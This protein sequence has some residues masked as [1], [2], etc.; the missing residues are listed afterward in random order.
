MQSGQLKITREAVFLH[1]IFC[2]AVV[3]L[4]IN[5]IYFYYRFMLRLTGLTTFTCLFFLATVY[6]GR[7]LCKT[8]YL[9][10]KP[11]HFSLYTVLSLMLMII[12]WPLVAKLIFHTP[13]D[14]REFSATTLPFFIIG[15]VM[16]ILIKLTRA[17]IQKQILDAQIKAEQKQSELDLLQSQLSPHF[18]FNTLNNL[19]GISITQHERVPALLLQLSDLLRYSVYD[20]K[21]DFVTLKE[22]LQYINNYISFEKIRMSDR[23]VLHTDIDPVY[24]G[25]IKIA[26]MVLIIFVENAFKHASNTLDQKIFIDIALTISENFI[27]FSVK[28]SHSDGRNENNL[29]PKSAGLGIANTVKRLYLL[30]EA[31]YELKRYSEN[32]LYIV[33]LRLKI[34]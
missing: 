2:L 11:F 21:K 8:W 16:G 18:L 27:V 24:S 4:V 15:L 25:S 17:S 13:G 19:Y 31:D 6:T 1:L 9:R 3:A 29:L 34:K 22:E 28:N 12:V 32:N 5:G 30:Y 7:W 26:P 20:T 33:N 14:I 23:L 10:Q